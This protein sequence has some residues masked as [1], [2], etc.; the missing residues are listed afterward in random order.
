MF[1]RDDLELM[2]QGLATLRP[3]ATHGLVHGGL[4][5]I[6]CLSTNEAV[7]S[8]STLRLMFWLWL[9]AALMSSSSA[10]KMNRSLS[11]RASGFPVPP[12]VSLLPSE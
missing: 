9:K 6:M 4:D 11:P 8:S 2:L 7:R 3:R 10:M 5:Q 1:A 12:A